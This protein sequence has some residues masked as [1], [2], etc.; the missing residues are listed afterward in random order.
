MQTFY[1][2]KNY[3]E[4]YYLELFD[5]G[6]KKKSSQKFSVSKKFPEIGRVENFLSFTRPHSRICISITY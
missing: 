5:I 1:H 3:L 6:A 2:L 4:L